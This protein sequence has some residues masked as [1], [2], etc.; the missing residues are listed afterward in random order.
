[1]DLKASAIYRIG[2]DGTKNKVADEA[3]SGL[4]V[5]P[6]RVYACQGSKKRLILLDLTKAGAEAPSQADVEVLAE[7]VQ[8]N[9]LVVTK[10]G[11]VYFTE[12]GKH[13]VS[14]YDPKTKTIRVVDSG[15]A[16]PNGIALSPDGGTLAVSDYQGAHVWT[17]VIQSDGSLSAKEP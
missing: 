5:L 3:G 4:K 13:Q 10:E 11:R 17:F 8:P 2:I 7:N 6:G 16:G 1:S 12:T 15:I 14:L 9:D